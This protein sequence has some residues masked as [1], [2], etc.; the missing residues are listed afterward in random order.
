MLGTLNLNF[1]FSSFCGCLFLLFPLAQRAIR[2]GTAWSIKRG[3]KKEEHAELLLR[4][5]K[6]CW[7]LLG[8]AHASGFDT[9]ELP[10]VSDLRTDGAGSRPSELQGTL[11]HLI[12]QANGIILFC[13]CSRRAG[14]SGSRTRA[15]M[16]VC[17]VCLSLSL[18]LSLSICLSPPPPIEMEAKTAGHGVVISTWARGWRRNAQDNSSFVTPPSR[19]IRHDAQDNKL[20]VSRTF[21]PHSWCLPITCGSALAA[22][23]HF[24]K[25]SEH[26]MQ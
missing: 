16:C 17:T 6:G 1:L 15:R 25:T 11:R 12:G 2:E 24:V 4:G 13:T 18:S 21:P 3:A 26:F 23:G 20:T 19:M 8:D 10:L 22:I 7:P 9:A 5:E 14:K